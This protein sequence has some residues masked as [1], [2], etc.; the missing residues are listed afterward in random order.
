MVVAMLALRSAGSIDQVLQ[1][2][3]AIL[4][5]FPPAPEAP[6]P[7]EAAPFMTGM[8]VTPRPLA[9]AALGPLITPGSHFLELLVIVQ[10]WSFTTLW[11]PEAIRRAISA[12][13]LSV[14][15]VV[16]VE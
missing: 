2:A 12:P 15:E 3:E 9:A 4:G 6:V 14:G 1:E 16:L 8:V 11:L 10:D 5:P 7:P 13:G